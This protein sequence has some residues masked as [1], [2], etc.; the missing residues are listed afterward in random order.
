MVKYMKRIY[1]EK[2]LI[3]HRVY[4]WYNVYTVNYKTIKKKQIEKIY[5]KEIQM[6][7]IYMQEIYTKKICI[8]KIKYIKK[9]CAR[10]EIKARFRFVMRHAITKTKKY[11]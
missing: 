9:Y 11:F 1:I 10:V 4:I 3:Y 7:K 6:K 8:Q 2:K 5:I